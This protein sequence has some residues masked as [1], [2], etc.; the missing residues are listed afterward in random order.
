MDLTFKKIVLA[1]SVIGVT[2]RYFVVHA[3]L[4]LLSYMRL[5]G[6][7]LICKSLRNSMKCS[8]IGS[9]HSRKAILIETHKINRTSR[10][11]SSTPFS[12]FTR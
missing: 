5:R 4:Y 10:L 2:H 1:Q 11:L 7:G 8:E 9:E 12:W 3:K 6:C